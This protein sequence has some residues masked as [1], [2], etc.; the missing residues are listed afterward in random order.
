[1]EATYLFFHTETTGIHHARLVQL[2]AILVNEKGEIIHQLDAIIRPDNFI[3]P[4]QVTEIHGITTQIAMEKGETI[5]KVMQQFAEL[6]MQANTLVAH[7]IDFDLPIIIGELQR[8]KE[9]ETI[10]SLLALPQIC[11]MLS[12]ADFVKASWNDNYGDW[13]W[14]QLQELHFKLFQSYFKQTHHAMTSVEII[15]KCFFELKSKHGFFQTKSI[16]EFQKL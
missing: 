14:P 10:D 11:T 13:K 15:V 3:I 8:L 5:K 6:M 16:T 2:G 12:T 4:H 9:V 1:M 7:N